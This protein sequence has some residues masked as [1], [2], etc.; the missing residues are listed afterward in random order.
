MGALFLFD[1][2][3]GV[4]LGVLGFPGVSE[5]GKLAS[6]CASKAGQRV[7]IDT[8]ARRKNAQSN[9]NVCSRQGRWLDLP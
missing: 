6:C 9:T 3:F 1:V 4:D 8:G 2:S 7:M 5:I